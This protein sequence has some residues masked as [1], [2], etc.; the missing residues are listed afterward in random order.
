MMVVLLPVYAKEQ[1]NIIESQYG[2][3]MA[4]NAAMVVLFQYFVTQRTKRHTSLP[5]L[6]LG[7]LF[8]G[9]GVGS[10][11]LG[12][13]FGAFW[14][15]MVIMTIGELIIAPTGTSFTANL[16]PPDMRGRYMG[17][18]GLTWAVGMGIGPVIGGYLSDRIAPVA[19]WYSALVFGLI[20]ALAFLLLSRLA[21]QPHRE[22]APPTRP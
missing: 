19:I 15:S 8:Y 14:L 13:S 4:T 12:Q 3:I 17:V 10:V 5:V 21:P 20:A 22:E 1:F 9:L 18:Y 11:A 16:S 6:A 2:F 7:A